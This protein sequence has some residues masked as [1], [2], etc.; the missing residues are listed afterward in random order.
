MYYRHRLGSLGNL[1]NVSGINDLWW[2]V[3]PSL[4][5]VVRTYFFCARCAAFYLCIR[6]SLLTFFPCACLIPFL[7]FPCAS[8]WGDTRSW[9]TKAL[10]TTA[11]FLVK[12]KEV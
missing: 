10:S 3:D 11:T 8:V 12:F 1:S 9:Y 6:S 4:C 7:L 2:T 5:Y